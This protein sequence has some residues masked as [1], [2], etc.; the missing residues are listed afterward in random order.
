NHL[1]HEV[2]LRAADTALPELKFVIMDFRRVTG[3]DASAIFSLNKVQQLARKNGFHLVMTQVSPQIVSQME[4]GGL[5]GARSDQIMM[6]P[7]LD[8]A[9]ECCED[10][11]LA[12]G[13]GKRNGDSRHL[14]D[15][16]K[17]AWP[18]GVEPRSLIPYLE[19]LEIPGATHLIRQSEKSESLYFIE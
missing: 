3:L 1:L 18:P 9:L 17:E 8:H 10:R 2:R 13:N 6:F 16:L 14:E 7:D 19:R 12:A 15:H 4:Q 11:L 5:S